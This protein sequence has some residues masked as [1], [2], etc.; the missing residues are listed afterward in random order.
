MSEIQS[1]YRPEQWRTLASDAL[2]LAA[3]LD[4]PVEKQSMIAIAETY[5][6]LATRVEQ[7]RE[8]ENSAH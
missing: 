1:T 6:H 3:E 5:V 2:E 7:L 8:K 4:D